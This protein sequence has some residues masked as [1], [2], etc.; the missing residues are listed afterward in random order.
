MTDD[1]T[2]EIIRPLKEKDR[3]KILFICLG[4]E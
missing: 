4:N 1:N 3:I 2:A